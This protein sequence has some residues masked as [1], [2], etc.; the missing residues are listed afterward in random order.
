MI[1]VTEDSKPMELTAKGTARRNYM[2]KRY[3][4]EID[5]LYKLVDSISDSGP[6][7]PT[8]W[9]P[10]KTLRFVRAVVLHFLEHSVA[11]Q[12]DLFQQ[13]CDRYT[14]NYHKMGYYTKRIMQFKSDFYSEQPDTCSP[15]VKDSDAQHSTNICLSASVYPIAH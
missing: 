10:D 2:L 12:D 8:E 6:S 14:S 1:I 4:E 3:E 9:T 5:S 13:G 7:P 15:L 11:D